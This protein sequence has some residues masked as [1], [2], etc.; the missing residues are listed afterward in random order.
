M[1]RPDAGT[2]AP[3]KDKMTA[4]IK[5]GTVAVCCMSH[6]VPCS[7]LG[8]AKAAPGADV[9]QAVRKVAGVVS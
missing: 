7:I 2:E 1:T 6:P 3:G 4:L 9:L 8:N 5:H